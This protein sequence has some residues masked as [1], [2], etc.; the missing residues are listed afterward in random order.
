MINA[1]M[2]KIIRYLNQQKETSYKDIEQALNIKER[3]VRYD[4]DCINDVL[5]LKGFP[6]IE[7]CSKGHLIVPVE[8]DLTVL[9]DDEFIFSSEERN[10]WLRFIILFDVHSLNIKQL[11]EK[12][13]VSRRSVQNGLNIVEKNLSNLGLSLVYNH[14]FHLIEEENKGYSIRVYE[15]KKYV[16]LF[17]KPSDEYN[18]F[19]QELMKLFIHVYDL[20]IKRIYKWISHK[21]KIMNWTF[22]DESFDWYVANIIV[23]CWY[24]LKDKPLPLCPKMID[25]EDHS[26]H[27]LE[28][29]INKQL[30]DNQKKLIM[31]Y[32]NYT[33]KYGDADINLDLIMTED[34]I[35]Q[36]VRMMSEALD[37]FFIRDMIL[38]KGLLN[39]A[40]P[41]LERIKNHVQVYEITNTVIPQNYAYVYETLS[42]IVLNIPA[43]QQVSHEERI[44]LS[45]HFIGSLQRLRAN[46]YKNILL[47]CGLGFGTTALLKDTLRSGYQVQVID[48]I[49]AYHMEHYDK[50]DQIDLVVS[51][52]KLSLPAKKP[53]VV[54]NPIFT[55][56]DH[57]QLEEAG[58]RKKNVLT[59]YIAI[60][61]R[62]SFLPPNDKEK[63]LEIIREELGYKDVR[64]PKKY[65][66]ISDLLGQD[67]IRYVPSFKN[68][69]DAVK[70]STDILSSHGCI[71][72]QYY[73]ELINTIQ[74]SGFYAVIH[75]KFALFHS[76]ST[77]SVKI[78]SMS[79]IVTHEPVWFDRKQ[80]RVIFCLASKDK[81]EHIPAIVKLMRMVDS[82]QLIEKL[83]QCHNQNDV[84]NAV[85]ECEAAVLSQY[86]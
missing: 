78:S 72:V 79:L 84:I 20:N 45:I 65:Y 34:I 54:V 80:V 2:F 22:S 16:Y 32:S 50:W 73:D 66:N 49:P 75:D 36:L 86:I 25:V 19:E 33:N 37:V 67:S 29:I 40:A 47:I 82:A 81:K 64:I 9:L 61:K 46:D 18:T 63:V 10:Q 57:S 31:S 41:M 11:S 15:L 35:L 30:D 17:A 13:Q 71:G 3:Q 77:S 48:S 70:L 56:A 85:N 55:Q 7:K 8:S 14:H 12:F 58:I 38:I 39:H 69:Q 51:T 42:N 62:L 60:E 53:L 52:S 4:I 1:R 83:E 76:G 27:G 43:L 68:W 24:V 6:E 44:Y 59:N 26:L 28:I 5:S 74:Q 21:I 23:T